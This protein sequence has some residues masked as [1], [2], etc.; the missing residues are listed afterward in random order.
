MK[1]Q[2]IMRNSYKLICAH[3]F[4]SI[5]ERAVLLNPV[6]FK[7]FLIVAGFRPAGGAINCIYS[8]NSSGGDKDGFISGQVFELSGPIYLEDSMNAAKTAAEH[9]VIITS[10]K[11]FEEHERS[12]ADE[13]FN[14]TFRQ[15]PTCGTTQWNEG[16]TCSAS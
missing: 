8:L 11:S 1:P 6:L 10:W 3:R 14:E 13:V 4:L 2:D 12:Y 16:K 5:Q 7:G 15:W 9:E